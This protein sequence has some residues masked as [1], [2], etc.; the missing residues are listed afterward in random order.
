MDQISVAEFPD[1]HSL[2]TESLQ[3][4]PL[5]SEICYPFLD[6][7]I[8]AYHM[9]RFILDRWRPPSR[10]SGIVVLGMSRWSDVGGGTLFQV[11]SLRP[12][13]ATPPCPSWVHQPAEL[14]PDDRDE[15]ESMTVLEGVG[16]VTLKRMPHF[17][18][19]KGV[20]KTR[21]YPLAHSGGFGTPVERE[22]TLLFPCDD[23]PGPL[24]L[25]S[26]TALLRSRT[27]GEDPYTQIVG[28]VSLG[29]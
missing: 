13:S 10:R 4:V 16:A 1:L 24:C 11:I 28:V 23:S 3:R 5:A 22:E 17:T 12:T 27:A 21:F 6:E 18:G 8:D 26:G 15:F 19:E 20:F 25:V 2:C 14:F 29:L 7:A 9:S